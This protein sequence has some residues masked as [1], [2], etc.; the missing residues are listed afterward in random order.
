ML[1]K[2]TG[3][4]SKDDFAQRF[5]EA[6]DAL[7]GYIV[8]HV[9]SLTDAEDILQEV[10]VVLWERFGDYRPEVPFI[11]W[12]MGIARH[13]ILHHRRSMA[14]SRILLDDELSSR[15]GE[16]YETLL[17]ELSRRQA[18]LRECVRRLSGRARRVLQMRYY[19]GLKPGTIA[20][21]MG[22]SYGNVQVILSRTRTWL[23]GC[24]DGGMVPE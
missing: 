5:V 16:R 13:K 14:R 7:R 21:R 10:S 11:R 8:S 24:V 3:M 17:S 9:G 4:P 20:E 19:D 18:A 22:L 15:F 23:R 2:G 12:A 1:Q 6:N